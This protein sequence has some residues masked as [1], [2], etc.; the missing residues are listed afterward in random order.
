[1]C[2]IIGI[3][4]AIPLLMTGKI[5]CDHLSSLQRYAGL[6]AEIEAKRNSARSASASWVWDGRGVKKLLVLCFAKK[7]DYFP[8][9]SVMV[10]KINSKTYYA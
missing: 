5:I 9:A 10:Q 7:S 3:L 6:S 2:G 1:M 8:T 4:L